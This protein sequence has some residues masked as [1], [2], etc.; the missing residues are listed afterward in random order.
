MGINSRNLRDFSV[1]LGVVER[2]AALVPPGVLLIAESGIKTAGDVAR[3]RR[4]G[5]RGALIGETLMR[6]SDRRV[7]LAYLRE[8]F[9]SETS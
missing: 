8:D 4:A 5:A 2:L 9:C 1:D 3:V 7:M 6:A